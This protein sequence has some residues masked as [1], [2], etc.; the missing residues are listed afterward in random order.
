MKKNTRKSKLLLKFRGYDKELL[1]SELKTIL[2]EYMLLA[3]SEKK[4]I[5]ILEKYGITTYL[6]TY[7]YYEKKALKLVEFAKTHN[8]SVP[9]DWDIVEVKDSDIIARIN[10]FKY[11]EINYVTE[12]N[13]LF[14]GY[15]YDS[16]GTEDKAWNANK[17]IFNLEKEKEKIINKYND[18]INKEFGENI[19]KKKK[20]L[21]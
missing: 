20:E 18:I 3:Q 9:V 15:Y 13:Y 10:E 6:S 11:D 14:D 12:H 8:L 4:A 1:L 21:N 5:E 19:L 2:Q 7:Q 16:V 17:T